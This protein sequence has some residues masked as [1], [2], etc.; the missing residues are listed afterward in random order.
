MPLNVDLNVVSY[1]SVNFAGTEGEA[2]IQQAKNH[3]GGRRP[4][5]SSS[6]STTTMGARAT[7]PIERAF[8]SLGN[9]SSEIWPLSRNSSRNTTGVPA[10]IS[11][12]RYPCCNPA[13]TISSLAATVYRAAQNPRSRFAGSSDHLVSEAFYL[14]DPDGLGIEVFM[15]LN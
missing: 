8:A 2:L 15:D 6:S 10:R 7:P 14:N 11:G 4:V 1:T 3:F 5:G 13:G 12:I 9:A